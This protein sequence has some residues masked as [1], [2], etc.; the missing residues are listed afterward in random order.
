MQLN[1]SLQY[2]ARPVT[3]FFQRDLDYIYRRWSF[4]KIFI[5]VHSLDFSED[6]DYSC[7]QHKQPIRH[8]DQVYIIERGYVAIGGYLLCA[9]AISDITLRILCCDRVADPF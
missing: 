3:V 1:E 7:H 9:G 4:S 5:S 6:V 8:H 2:D